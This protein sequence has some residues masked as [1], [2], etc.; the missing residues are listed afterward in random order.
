MVNRLAGETSPYL[1]QHA[2]QAVDW[3]PW[4]SSALADA[5][6]QDKPILL[7]IGYSACHWCHVMAHESFDDPRIAAQMN[8]DFVNIKV[9]REERPDVDALYMESVQ[10]MTGHGGWPMTVFLTP[11]GE[12]FYG[13]TYY[14]PVARG[15]MPG[16]S[17]VLSAIADAWRNR[18]EEVGG[19]AAR[20]AEAIRRTA[21][22]SAVDGVLTQEL[23]LAGEA[24]ARAAFDVRHGGFGG[25][26]KFPSAPTLRFVF[27]QAL[28]K[29]DADLLHMAIATLGEMARGGLRDQIGGGFH[30]YCVDRDWTVPH[31]EKMLYDNTQLAGLYLDAWRV[32]G[33]DLLREV[34]EET[35]DWL[36]TDMQAQAPGAGFFASIDADTAAGE[37]AYYAWRPA[38][39]SAALPEDQARA[40]L[41][42]FGITP[43]GN[44]EDGASVLTARR[45]ADVVADELG[46]DVDTLRS[47]LAQ[48]RPCLQAL[49]QEREAPAVDRKIITS[50]NGEAIAVLARA[51]A[52]LNRADYLGAADRA[53][54]F[55]LGTVVDE[56][57]ALAHSWLD[58]RAGAP[59]FLEDFGAMAEATLALFEATFDP[60]WLEEA[61]LLLE[62]AT[63]LFAAPD[64]GFHRSGARHDRLFARQKE[65]TDGAVPS[66]NAL[67]AAAMLRAS[68]LLGDPE[69]RR[70]VTDVLRVAHPILERA[71]LAAPRLLGVLEDYLAGSREVAIVGE[72]AAA[73]P[74][75][76]Q[77]RQ[78][79][80]PGTVVAWTAGDAT[81]GSGVPLL[82]DRAAPEGGAAAY[83]C[84]AFACR[85]PVHTA[86]DLVEALGPPWPEAHG[87]VDDR[88]LRPG[89][90]PG[91]E[92]AES[93]SSAGTA[94]EPRG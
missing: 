10:A 92:A 36:L 58:G 84:R 93:A 44:F 91:G 71:P 40:V 64:G 68:S 3:Y 1:L 32:T 81:T 87:G 65:I 19:S 35:L 2:H 53:A 57:G 41:S 37:G 50:W 6:S 12:P 82:Q 30:R 72:P 17:D 89:F 67:A 5:Q 25:A 78:R 73:G 34:A 86:E 13:G 16:F 51:G 14:P 79:V 80:M 28:R 47:L 54:R 31:F 63:M 33:L 74:M 76:A 85:A 7:S 62:E 38:E 94:S 8:R 77:L 66:G 29:Q 22:P 11:T 60:A 61:R 18:R 46:L 48:A 70:R 83:V 4:G 43:A 20:L 69:L 39:I 88:W 55:V 45:T 24:A 49:R 52:V 21:A 23:G 9:D 56:D 59:A 75:L 90:R 27:D 26:P 42:W 15:G